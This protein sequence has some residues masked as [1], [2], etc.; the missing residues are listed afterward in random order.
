MSGGL[1]PGK[2]YIVATPI[3]NLEDMTFRAV[4]IL[5]EADFVAS[6]D[7]RTT[8]KLLSAYDIHTPLISYHEQGGKSPTGRIV[9]RIR[10]G[11]TVALVSEAGTPGISDPGFELVRDCIAEGIEPLPIPGPSALV[12][13]LSVSDVPIHR[14]VFEGFLPRKG[15][16]R[17]ERIEEIRDDPRTL[18]FYEAPKRLKDTLS[19]LFEI[20]GDRRVV[21]ARE[22]T[23]KFE[24]VRRG[25]LS[26]LIEWAGERE[27]K[28]ELTIVVEGCASSPSP[29][30]DL[31]RRIQFLK[32]RCGL[33]DRDVVR[34]L[35]EETGLPRKEIYP[36]LSDL[37]SEDGPG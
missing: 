31:L 2:L 23:K 33:S 35:H 25:K 34:V 36:L 14:F 29:Q 13:A 32:E 12:A 11:K 9:S 21:V 18:V 22:L 37:K 24:E 15:Q 6:E 30:E 5:K 16:S 4:R 19:D 27:V 26:G 28:G 7:T 8:R 20:L 10:E 17:I 3:G 1:E